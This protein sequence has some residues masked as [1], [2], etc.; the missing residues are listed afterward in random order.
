MTEAAPGREPVQIVEILQPFCANTFGSAPCT[1]TGTDDQKCYNTRATCRDSGGAGDNFALGTP[2]SLFFSRGKV[3]RP[4]GV[5]YLIPSLVSV[6]TSPTRINLAAA[7]P[8]ASGLGNR[9]V[10]S[11]VFGDHQ[12]TDAVVDPYLSGRSWNSLDRARGSFWTRWLARNRYRTGVVI[13]V[14]EGYAGQALSAMSVRTYFLDSV[15][16]PDASGRVTITGKD[17]LAKLEERKAQA[18]LASPG[19]LAAALSNSATSFEAAGATAS[20]YAASGTLRIGDEIMTYSSRANSSGGVTF[21]GVLRGRDNTTA[22]AHDAA[23]G[24][25]QCL[26]YTGQSIDAILS[27]LLQTYAGVPSTWLDLAGWASEVSGFLSAYLLTALITE[28]TAVAELVAEIQTQAT[29]YLWWDERAAQVKLKALRAVDTEPPLLTERAHILAG[30]FALQEKPRE[31]AS[32]VWVYYN[33][34]D[35]VKSAS[36]PKGYAAASIFANLERETAEFY[37]EPSIRK[38]FGR[39]LPTGALAGTTASKII[40]LY[41][42]TPTSCRFRLDAKD[43]AYWIGDVVRIEHHLDV[44]PFGLPRVRQW[45]IV[46]A[47]EVVPGEVV[48]YVAEDTT[49]YGRIYKILPAGAADYPGADLAGYSAAY[50]G[51]AAGLLSDGE[52]AARIT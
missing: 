18:P 4:A 25:Q 7:N 16:H 17:I 1:A 14:Y 22:V 47:E 51:G 42:D 6:S 3:A 29:C 34:Q 36:D 27:D 26:R 33:R 50:I 35:F 48:E 8:D 30:S 39:W 49:L 11:L 40:T 12:H 15:S 38:V 10:C 32:Q 5:P 44:G 31:R 13:R 43:R 45:L 20:D 24:V 52:T 41:V 9:G 28:P 46:S 19:V 23:A 37:G 21:S 2:L